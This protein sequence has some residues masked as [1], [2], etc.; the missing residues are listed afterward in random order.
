M[1]KKQNSKNS[2]DSLPRQSDQKMK[3]ALFAKPSMIRVYSFLLGVSFIASM[4][5]QADASLFSDI[6][7]I[8]SAILG[9]PVKAEEAQVLSG[10]SSS[11]DNSQ[12]MDLSINSS[13]HSMNP[14]L[15]NADTNSDMVIVQNNSFIYSDEMVPPNVKF[16]KSTISDQIMVYTVAEGDTLSE[17]A[18][19]FDV[20][21]N[22]IRWENNI[23]GNTVPVGKKLNIL[24][25]T[26]VKHIV[27]SGDTIS[28]IASKYE[29]DSDDILI[30]NGLEKGDALK[31]GDI[32]FV[33]NGIKVAVTKAVSGSKVTYSNTKAPSGYYLRPVSG[34]VTSPYGSRKGG[35]HPGV[36]LAGTKGVTPVL[37]SASG[38]VVQAISGCKEGARSCGGRYGNYI[39]IQHSNGT[40]TRY[41]HLS[42]TKVSIG[43]SVSQGQTIGILGNTG[44]STGPH[45]HFEIINANGSKMR[46]AI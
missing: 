36:D 2:S 27:G 23:T 17:I 20:S 40:M 7:D 10:R 45:V 33:P 26:G 34:R 44:Y 28:K 1:T 15:K 42:S 22:T 46:P 24:P 29:A 19:A 6:S 21:L 4:P 3:I 8:A 38:V 39:T 9:T 32:V 11:D 37:A 14:D 12:N 31:K 25:M 35:F 41:A 43:Q 13:E 30:F 5:F 18:D 16:E